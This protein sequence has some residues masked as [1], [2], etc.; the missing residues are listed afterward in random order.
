M[1]MFGGLNVLGTII[2]VICIP[3]TLN[4]TVSDEEVALFEAE[5]EDLMA[6]R[7]EDENEKK[8]ARGINLWTV[9]C[10]RHAFFTMLISFVGT[11]DIVF[12]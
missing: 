7:V 11:F 12:F 8:Y 4:K 5:M 3:S 2:C 1:Y 10:N 6:I 9:L